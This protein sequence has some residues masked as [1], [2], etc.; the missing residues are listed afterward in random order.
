MLRRGGRLWPRWRRVGMQV[1]D[2]RGDAGTGLWHGT[3]GAAMRFGE[4]E[5]GWECGQEQSRASGLGRG[6]CALGRGATLQVSPEQLKEE[7][8]GRYVEC[9]A[10]YYV[11]AC[12]GHSLAYTNSVS[13]PAYSKRVNV[14]P[15]L[16]Q[17]E[18]SYSEISQGSQDDF[19]KIPRM[20]VQY[21]CLDPAPTPQ[22]EES[23][24]S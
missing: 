4:R 19:P 14:I 20:T 6:S 2:R 12:W 17:S 8:G 18:T 5:I 1:W 10:A 24:Q 22:I 21:P 11:S 15:Y 9:E 23:L 3:S 16:R 7:W 13:Q